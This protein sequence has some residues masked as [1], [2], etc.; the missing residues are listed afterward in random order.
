[1]K[2]IVIDHSAPAHFAFAERGEPDPAPDEAVVGVRAISLNLG[3]LRYAQTKEAGSPTGWDLAGIVE[4]PASDGSGPREGARVVGFLHSGAWA[5]RAAVP[6]HALAELPDGVGFAE[7]AT[8]PVAGLTALKVVDL[9][10]GLLARRALVTGASG[11]VGMFACQIA[12]L[13]GAHVT[14]LIRK[15]QYEEMVRKVADQVVVSED[16]SAAAEFGPYR[17]IAESVGGAVLSNV[18]SMLEHD[19]VCATYG[20]SA[21]PEALINV[22]HL[23]LPGRAVLYGFLLFNE[24]AVETAGEGLSRLVRLVADGRLRT[25]ITVEESW[26]RLPAVAVDLWERRIPGKAVLHVRA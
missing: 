18:I 5:E 19:G 23:M 10:R 14:A 2:A 21:D 6:T 4:R 9:A 20:G 16:G 26:E 11:G 17:L 1:M 3:E 8:L 25:F 24:L 12:R 7:A 22:R 13:A 15:P